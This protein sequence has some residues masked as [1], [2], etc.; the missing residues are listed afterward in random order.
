M[1]AGLAFPTWPDMN[2]QLIPSA[3]FTETPTIAGFVKYNAQDFWG[4]TL[5]QFLHRTTAYILVVLMVLFMIKSKG[6]STDKAFTLGLNLFPLAVLLQALIGIV[7]VM[8]CVGKIPV[9][10]GVVH[11]AGAMFLIAITIFVIFH[12]RTTSPQAK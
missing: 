5:I 8:N 1:K 3:L 7:T 4:R 6:V 9:F 11:Q 12:L 2:G 10:W